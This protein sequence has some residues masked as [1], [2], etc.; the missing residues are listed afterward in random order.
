MWRALMDWFPDYDSG[1]MLEVGSLTELAGL[2]LGCVVFG[3]TIWVARRQIQ[4][5]KLQTTMMEAQGNLAAK[6]TEL[7][8]KQDAI[9]Q[10]QLLRAAKLRVRIDVAQAFHAPE[11]VIPVEVFNHGN[12]T[13]H[14][15]FWELLVPDAYGLNVRCVDVSGVAVPSINGVVIDDDL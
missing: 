5:M 2:A 10:E 13:A 3:F 14:G 6:Q 7:A 9:I 15:F 11:T 4:I 1:S 12:K 8:T